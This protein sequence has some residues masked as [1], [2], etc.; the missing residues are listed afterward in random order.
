VAWTLAQLAEHVG[1]TVHGDPACNVE[2]VATL[3]DAKPGQISFLTNSRYKSSLK[4]TNASA[5]ILSKEFVEECPVNAIVTD[6]PHAT[7]ARIAQLLHPSIRAVPG[8]HSTAIIDS[9]VTLGDNVSIGPYAVIE[10]NTQI[11]DNSVIGASCFIGADVTIGYDTRIDANTSI[12]HGTHIG[13]RCILFSGVVIGSDGFGYAYDKSGWVKIPQIGKVFI[14]DDVE[15]G[16][17]TT[18]DRGSIGNTVIENGVKLDNLVHIAHNV[19]IGEQSVIAACCGIAGS[20]VIG[21]R[22]MMGGI[23]GISGH[24]EITDDVVLTGMSTVTKSIRTPGTYSSTMPVEPVEVWRRY[25][26]RFKLLDSFTKRLK[27]LEKLV[28]PDGK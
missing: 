9:T 7:Y 16:T 17:N 18:I 4:T 12:Y 22:C 28:K 6:N 24:I 11:G 14:G 20:T 5:I 26:A 10:G 8:V 27:A 19:R 21:K 3:D 13:N 1:G 2:S 23:C 15:I 25:V